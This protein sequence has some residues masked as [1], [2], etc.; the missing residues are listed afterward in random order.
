MRLV[1]NIDAV[2]TLSTCLL[3]LSMVAAGVLWQCGGCGSKSPSHD[4]HDS[5]ALIHLIRSAIYIS[6]TRHIFLSR[7]LLLRGPHRSLLQQESMT[8]EL[9]RHFASPTNDAFVSCLHYHGSRITNKLE[10]T[11]K[12]W[13]Q[14]NDRRGLRAQVRIGEKKQGSST[15]QQDKR[16]KSSG[17][18]WSCCDNDRHLKMPPTENTTVNRLNMTGSLLD[19][20]PPPHFNLEGYMCPR[21]SERQPEKAS[22]RRAFSSVPER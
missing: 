8:T 20:S 5:H 3:P 2:P 11:T 13:V 4:L 15:R 7:A 21:T 19:A 18:D 6:P 17:S 9:F 16:T 1:Y 10:M 22:A 12:G 14:W